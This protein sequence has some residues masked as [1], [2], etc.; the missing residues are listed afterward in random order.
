MV[1]SIKLLKYISKFEQS[2]LF[3]SVSTGKTDSAWAPTLPEDD[4]AT[5]KYIYIYI[6][7]YTHTRSA[8]YNI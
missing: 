6:Y 8:S 7:I 3:I 5:G 4:L 2:L 1:I